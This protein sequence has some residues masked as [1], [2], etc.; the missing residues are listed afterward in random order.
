MAHPR[1]IDDYVVR[2]IAD[3]IRYGHSLQW[4]QLK[5]GEAWEIISGEVRLVVTG[6]HDVYSG[7]G[8]LLCKLRPEKRTYVLRRL[9]NVLE[10]KF[11][12]KRKTKPD[13]IALVR[14][15]WK[16]AKAKLTG[17]YR[18]DDPTFKEADAEYYKLTGWHLDRRALK[19]AGCPVRPD[20]RGAKKKIA[21]TRKDSTPWQSLNR[22]PRA[23]T[24]NGGRPAT[25]STVA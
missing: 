6:A 19:D 13:E 20:K 22:P 14:Q 9:I 16:I 17:L 8:E 25:D 18:G 23:V 3:L 2:R 21:T 24:L 5:D 7:I 15:A 12:K 10:G 1:K 11:D 4:S